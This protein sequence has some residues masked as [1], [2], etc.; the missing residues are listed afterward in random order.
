MIVA[1]S[2]LAD[3][4]ASVGADYGFRIVHLGLAHAHAFVLSLFLVLDQV[5]LV[6]LVVGFG[7]YFTILYHLNQLYNT[8]PT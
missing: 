5:W 1:A 3:L 7:V 6:G 4:L 8:K 2:V